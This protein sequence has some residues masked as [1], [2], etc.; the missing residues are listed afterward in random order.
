MEQSEQRLKILARIAEYEKAGRFNDDVEEDAPT[1]PLR[2]KDV[3]YVN[4]KLSSKFLTVIANFLGKTFF[5]NMIKKNK[6]IIKEITGLDN[7]K[8]DS[9][10]IITCNHFNLRDNY[11]VNRALMPIF[12]KGQHLYKVIKES[13]YTNFKGPVRLMMR[14]ANTLPLSSDFE[15]MK[16]FYASVK[17]LLS[18]GE[19]ILI[20]P[21]QAM[22]FNYRKP[23]PMQLGAFRLAARFGAPVLPVFIGMKDSEFIDDE[24]FPV[25]EYYMH[26]LPPIYPDKSLS[27]KENAVIM[28]D[29]NYALWVN[30]YEEFY[31]EQLTY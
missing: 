14:H 26:F 29:K 10:A 24:G 19:K 6:F 11:A 21:E 7:A 5:E 9:G 1:P 30:C 23:R 15:T 8:T 22:W 2:P 13:N 31:K 12:R 28:R 16:K 18:R 17:T 4:K 20:Y 27:E 25:Q 3:D